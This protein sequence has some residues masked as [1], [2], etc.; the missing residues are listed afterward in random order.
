MC[1]IWFCLGNFCTANVKKYVNNIQKRG[2]EDTRII[3]VAHAGTMGFNRLAINGLNPEGMQPMSVDNKTYWMCNGEIYNWRS[4]AKE[5][6]IPVKSDSDCE[7]LGELYLK[8]RDNLENFFQLLD[9]VF[10]IVIVDLEKN[11]V[12]IG[13]DPYGVRPL[14]VGDGRYF[15]SE[16]K[17]L[18]PLCTHVVPFMPGTYRVYKS[19]TL[20]LIKNEAYFKIPFLKNPHYNEWS[21]A[22]KG[23]RIALETAVEKRMLTERPVASLLSGGLDS[24]LIASLVAKKLRELELPPLKTFCIGMEGSTDIKY[25]RKVAEFIKSQHTEIVLT[26]DDFFNA[27]PQ[28]IHDI[29]SFDTTSVRASVGNWLVSKYI[30]ENT[31]CKVVFNGDGSDELFGSYMYFYNAPNDFE[32][33]K[34]CNRLLKDIHY[35]DVLRSDRSISSHGLEPRTPFLDR[36]FTQVALSVPTMFRRPFKDC[37]PEKNLLREAFNDEMTLPNEVLWRKKEAFSDGVSSLEKSWYEIIQEKVLTLVPSDWEEVSK[38]YTHLPPTTPEQFYYRTIFEKYYKGRANTVPYFW[39]P[40]W[41]EGVTDPSARTLKVY[42][43]LKN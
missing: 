4:L 6:D 35:F 7:V 5:Y 28:V 12:I 37:A 22:V 33:E 39:M 21:N 19:H 43:T 20:N 2:P 15:S 14:Y 1:G 36:Q 17:G 13:R 30:S 42:N 16:I 34:E 40:R 41:C 18:V 11:Q 29:E 26:P 24:S 25:A 27:I 38:Q 9:G 8:N 23:V 3:S 31:D 32:F 10:A